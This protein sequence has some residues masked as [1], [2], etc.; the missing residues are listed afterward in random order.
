MA[1]MPL[2]ATH[3]EVVRFVMRKSGP[4][5]LAGLIFSCLCIKLLIGRFDRYDVL[6]IGTL[7]SIRGLVEWVVHRYLLH[8][9]PLPVLGFRLM[10]PAFAMHAEH[11]R[12]P[13]LLDG[14]LFKARSVLAFAVAL[15]LLFVLLAGDVGRGITLL[16][17]FL[18]M[19]LT[20]EY[21]HV[22][23]H[24][25]V[26]PRSRWLKFLL[27]NHRQHHEGAPNRFLGVSSRLGDRL[28][29]TGKVSVNE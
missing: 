20:Y 15:G 29:E 9:M 21:F 1:V 26:V 13:Q 8:A 6:L 24:S 2:P 25:A 27:A 10:T 5:T 23:S 28:F 7:L 16:L 4:Q 22:L 3:A 11:H 19:L 18:L 14:L 12:N 17:S